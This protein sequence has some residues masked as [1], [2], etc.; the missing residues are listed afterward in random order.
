MK[1]TARKPFRYGSAVYM[2]GQQVS[3]E[4]GDEVKMLQAQGKIGGPIV[5][6][7]VE[8]KPVAEKVTPEPV[9]TATVRPVE[10][11]MKPKAEPKNTG[12]NKARK[13]DLEAGD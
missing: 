1:Y 8:P 2:T 4:E 7:K 9:E 3:V 5:E 13:K 10:N 6:A 11:A 12:G